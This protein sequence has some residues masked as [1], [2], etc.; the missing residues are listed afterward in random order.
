MRSIELIDKLIENLAED[1]EI[2]NYYSD[3]LNWARERRDDWKND[4]IR[5]GVIGVT[6]SGKSTLIN[7]LLASNI[8]SSAVAPSSGQLVCCSYG[9][10]YLA[11]IRLE[12]KKV[13]VLRG[14]DFREKKLMNYSDERKNPLNKKKVRS[15]EIQS[16]NYGL[17]K[18]VLLIDS[19][20]LDAYG[21]EIH[22][23][24]TLDT[25]VP[26]IDVCIY[27]TTM[28]ADNDAKTREILNVVSKYGCPL[29]I[30]QNMLDTVGD[31]ASGDKSKQQR[32]R[33]HRLK[34]EK[35]V[36]NSD[37]KNKAD[38]DIIQISAKYAMEWRLKESGIKASDI[39]R[40][41]FDSS[42]YNDLIYTVG[43]FLS[44]RKPRIEANRK[45]N[46]K[47]V[48][49]EIKELNGEY[50]DSLIDYD[51]DHYGKIKINI[52]EIK[53]STE[54]AFENI[55]KAI[56][57]N[58]SDIQKKIDS[59]TESDIKNCVKFVNKLVNQMGLSIHNEIE[60]SNMALSEIASE[61]NIPIR[62][63]IKS[64]SLNVYEDLDIYKKK[65]LNSVK[66]KDKGI[67]AFFMRIGGFFSDKDWGYH[68]S[69]EVTEVI[70]LEKTKKKLYRRLADSF[71]RYEDIYKNWYI[72][73]LDKACKRILNSI[74]E[75]E[76]AVNNRKM[77]RIS[78]EKLNILNETLNLL[79]REMGDES[80]TDSEIVTQVSQ[81]PN[82]QKT[83]NTFEADDFLSDMIKMARYSC[84]D[85]HREIMKQY[86]LQEKLSDYDA[87]IVG[88]DEDCIKDLIWQSGICDA[89]IFILPENEPVIDDRINPK[90]FF[91]M[92]NAV[93]IGAAEKQIRSL[94]LEKIIR[95]TDYIIWV[96]Q[97]FNEMLNS[98]NVE[99]GLGLLAE[100][101]KNC[102]VNVP[103]V[104][105]INH[106]NPLYN[107][108]YLKCQQIKNISISEETR[109]LSE[110]KEKFRGL[111]DDG[112]II[113]VG[114]MIRSRSIRRE[115]EQ[116][117]V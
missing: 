23:K 110:L 75:I 63:L 18:D 87:V 62:D 42:N 103:S 34:V 22:E 53:R 77:S 44:R 14:N 114:K 20:G 111:C 91:I 33:E 49:R 96:L 50:K 73:T 1:K 102:L 11:K 57:P 107:F 97:D 32:I 70:D 58:A 112:I 101:Q 79:L 115:T 52:Y 47:K 81:S 61:L 38:V 92:V 40:E 31:S 37:I 86:I 43:V 5:V 13:I 116:Y 95:P 84:R 99:E 94:N 72:G 56:E 28:K 67:I 39:T 82:K 76:T 21:L 54:K 8:L 83:I 109:I 106:R 90:C 16:P 78:Q 10:E 12:N 89:R 9:P 4:K 45:T 41:E 36:I 65:I 46:I 3:K 74:E 93:Q 85:Q 80:D 48:I 69:N 108:C 24:L 66:E 29:I 25:L 35:I 98:D 19:P 117:D 27:V 68:V 6:S 2:A 55:K 60:K 17:E 113:N 64:Q 105:W 30:V 15:I 59:A 71:I 7:A 88:W 104:I 100:L 51:P 26:T